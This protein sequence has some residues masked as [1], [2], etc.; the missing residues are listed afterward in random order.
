MTEMELIMGHNFDNICNYIIDHANP[1]MNINML[2]DDS[3]I[4]CKTNYL[5][6][7]FIF[8][9]NSNKNYI[10]ISGR[11]DSKITNEI[12]IKKPKCIIK[13]FAMNNQLNYSDIISLPLGV[14]NSYGCEKGSS[15]IIDDFLK[16]YNNKVKKDFKV[17]FNCN[18]MNNVGERMNCYNSLCKNKYFYSQSNLRFSEYIHQ[19]NKSF[20]VASPEGNGTDCHRTWEALYMGSIPIV[21][22]HNIFKDCKELPILFIDSWKQITEKFLEEKYEYFNNTSFNLEKLNINYWFDI[23]K[24]K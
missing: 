10:L 3:I 8:L 9:K 20:F 4:F 24:G 6:D 22:N 2:Q 1:T 15:I 11:G 23:I 12:Y 16:E 5:S 14:E 7:L 18:I 19:V 21:K 13:W 17:Y